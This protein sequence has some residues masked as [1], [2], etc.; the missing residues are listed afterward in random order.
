ML[1]TLSGQHLFFAFEAG[2]NAVEQQR[3]I[4]DRIN[5]YPVPDG[6]TGSNLSFT[7]KSAVENAEAHESFGQTLKSLAD[8]ILLGARGNSGLLFAQFI[9]GLADAA[10][11]LFSLTKEG[12]V[13]SAKKAVESAYKAISNPVEGTMLTVMREW[14]ESMEADH[15]NHGDILSLLSRG[16][17]R[18]RISLSQTKEKLAAL[19]KANQIDAGAK[20]FVE[21]LH[22]FV[23]YLRKVMHLSHDHHKE[24][25]TGLV[26]ARAAAKLLE[27]EEEENH[28]H[29]AVGSIEDIPN[30]FCTECIISGK[31]IAADTLREELKVF[32][33]SLI[34]AGSRNR[35]RI[36]IHTNNPAAVFKRLTQVGLVSQQ[37]ADDMHVQHA[38]AQGGH[39]KIALLVDSTCDIPD[40]E[41]Y[42]HKISMVPLSVTFGEQSFIDRI[43]LDA[44]HFYDLLD[45]SKD[46]PQTSQPSPAVFKR[47]FQYLG[48]HA[49]QIVALHL[50][51]GLSGTYNTSLS[52]AES[53]NAADGKNKIAVVDSKMASAGIGLCAL[54]C[55]DDIEAGVDFDTVVARLRS[56]IDKTSFFVTVSQLE[57]LIRG[58]R[59]SGLRARIVKTFN[60]RPLITTDKKDGKATTI[61]VGFGATG[62]WNKALAAIKSLVA[63]EKVH[64]WAIAHVAAEE[65]MHSLIPGLEQLLGKP[66]RLITA[67][68]PVLGAHT[69]PGTINIA[70]LPE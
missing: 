23:E 38:I 62:S 41:L 48:S 29:D 22:G 34:V 68:S 20:G 65:K 31:D 54:R 57:N 18:A 2:S 52:E 36:H 15:H 43:T 26:E 19:R 1:K 59:L 30:R 12:L 51:S 69:G 10:G 9:N 42:K 6:D 33:D 11:D 58:G 5:V 25:K 60:L 63:K 17:E 46:F 44:S 3:E 64:S 39:R 24:M 56:Y 55:S 67:A 13:S 47:V 35:V 61:A 70:I 28:D 4:I 21:F 50:S 66:P 37:K 7:M 45:A 16:L 32:G 27:K 40:E 8:S 14:S 53:I 49:D